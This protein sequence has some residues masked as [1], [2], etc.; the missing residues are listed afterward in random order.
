MRR[1]T[2]VI[3]PSTFPPASTVSTTIALGTTMRMPGGGPVSADITHTVVDLCP[4]WA[5]RS[6]VAAWLGLSEGA[7]GTALASSAVPVRRREIGEF[8]YLN[9]DDLRLAAAGW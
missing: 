5:R 1:T 3:I 7:F 2:N 6:V 8:E 9:A 4:Q